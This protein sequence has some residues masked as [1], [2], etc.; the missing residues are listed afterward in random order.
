VRFLNL[1]GLVAGETTLGAELSLLYAAAAIARSALAPFSGWI[2]N[3]SAFAA[4]A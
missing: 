1:T 4:P 2:W 3:G